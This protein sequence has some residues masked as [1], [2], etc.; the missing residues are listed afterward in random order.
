[1][2]ENFQKSNF[3][4]FLK[5]DE[6]FGFSR[7]VRYEA[8]ISKTGETHLKVQFRG[9]LAQKTYYWEK[10]Y[11]SGDATQLHGVGPKKS[12]I[13]PY[14]EAYQGFDVKTVNTLR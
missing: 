11:S 4:G 3:N 8:T 1:M 6:F 13:S 5:N 7:V 2:R 10:K 9:Y 14:L 12:P